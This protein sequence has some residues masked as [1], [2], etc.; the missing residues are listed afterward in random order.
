MPSVFDLY[1]RSFSSY[2]AIAS[3]SALNVTFLS[4]FSGFIR[5]TISVSRKGVSAWMLCF[6]SFSLILSDVLNSLKPISGVS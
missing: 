2:C 6:S 3:I 1:G 5:P 4:G